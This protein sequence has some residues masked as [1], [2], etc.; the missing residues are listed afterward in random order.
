MWDCPTE[1]S[2]VLCLTWLLKMPMGNHAS[3]NVF[4]ISE[5]TSRLHINT[6][7][8]SMALSTVSFPELQ[9]L[10]KLRDSCNLF[11]LE[12]T[13]SWPS[14]WKNYITHSNMT[15][16]LWTPNSTPMWMYICSSCISSGSTD[17]GKHLITSLCLLTLCL[18]DS[19]IKTNIFFKIRNCF[20]Y[21]YISY[22]GWNIKCTRR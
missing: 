16:G 20:P 19:Y 8:F 21:I 15:H 14:F 10:G 11:C 7:H 6:K 22:S 2:K 3:K 17:Y 9:Q 12:F 5:S 13:K 4:V 18:P 1:Q